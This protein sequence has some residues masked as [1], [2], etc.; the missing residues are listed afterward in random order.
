[1]I[2]ASVVDV[3]LIGDQLKRRS[4]LGDLRDRVVP[5]CGRGRLGD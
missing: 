3:P 4:N 1:M 2:E 5:R